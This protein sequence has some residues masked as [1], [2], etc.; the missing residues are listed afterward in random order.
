MKRILTSNLLLS[1]IALVLLIIGIYFSVKYS[2]F[3]WLSRFG[4][5]VICIGIIVLARPNILGI[6]LRPNI[7]MTTGKSQ[8]DP[9]HYKQS[10]EPLPYW[11]SEDQRSRTAVDWLG[12]LL[13]FIG[14]LTNGF[15][16]L[17]NVFLK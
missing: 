5:L 13:C 16:D 15:A 2:N 10:G 17:L 6:E 8:L 11:F 14:T 4:A 3:Q 1:T 7:R 9:E 12:P